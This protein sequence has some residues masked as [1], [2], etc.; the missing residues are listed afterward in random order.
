[1]RLLHIRGEESMYVNC[2]SPGFKHFQTS[3]RSKLSKT[4]VNTLVL[5]SVT[6]EVRSLKL[7]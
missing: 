4:S 5:L 2:T 7:Y 6:P 1:M 3:T